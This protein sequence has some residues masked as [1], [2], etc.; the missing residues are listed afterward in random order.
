MKNNKRQRRRRNN[1]KPI[2]IIGEVNINVIVKEYNKGNDKKKNY[3]KIAITMFTLFGLAIKIIPNI[4][5]LPAIIEIA[6]DAI[7]AILEVFA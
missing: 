5:N 1:N 7:V 6:T 4:D 2:I 3:I